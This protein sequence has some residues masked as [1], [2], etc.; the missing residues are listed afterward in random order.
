MLGP[1]AAQSRL[2]SDNV[3]L[4]S[5]QET[6]LLPCLSLLRDMRFG[7]SMSRLHLSV[8]AAVFGDS[9]VP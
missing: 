4:S 3:S 8:S 6:G 7:L 5:L 1:A 9:H 2:L